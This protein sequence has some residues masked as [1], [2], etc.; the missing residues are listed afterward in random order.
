MSGLVV[1]GA[2]WCP[3][4]VRVNKVLT[5]CKVAFTYDCEG[6]SKKKALVASGNGKIP[7]VCL[8]D[9]SFLSE[10]SDAVLTARLKELKLVA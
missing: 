4:C 1:I 5:K 10:P 6:D 7:C 8:P 2:D 9:G 3:D